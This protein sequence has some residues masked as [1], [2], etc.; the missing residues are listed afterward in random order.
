MRPDAASPTFDKRFNYR[1]VV[2]KLNLLKKS[3]MPDIAYAAHQCER[4][5]PDPQASHMDMITRLVKYLKATR[6]QGNMLDPKGV[7]SFEVYTDTGLCG[8]VQS[9][10]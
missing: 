8:K 1:P 9:S 2:G 7:N 10:R 4:F 3:T 5:S 6:Y